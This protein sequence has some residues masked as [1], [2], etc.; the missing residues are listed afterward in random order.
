MNGLAT[1]TFV[2]E[3][4]D[5]AFYLWADHGMRG[6]TVVHV[7]AHVDYFPGTC[8]DIGSYIYHA[9]RRGLI[10]RFYWV[11]PD[12]TWQSPRLRRRLIG[13][14]IELGLQADSGAAAGISGSLQG[15]HFWVGPLG[16]LPQIDAPVLLD[17][18]VD[19][20]LTPFCYVGVR[21]WL[22]PWRL[23][24][25]LVR[26]LQ[27]RQIRWD[28]ATIA[29]SVEGGYTPMQWRLLAPYTQA[30]LEGRSPGF[31]LS[32]L[33]GGA[34]AYVLGDAGGARTHFA[35]AARAGAGTEEQAAAE[36]WLARLSLEAGDPD[37]ARRHVRA[38][39]SFGEAYASSWICPGFG[40]WYQGSTRAA[41]R[42]FRQ[43]SQALPEEPS[44]F[45]LWA[46]AVLQDDP[47]TAADLAAWAYALGPECAD[48]NLAL[49]RALL[50]KGEPKA[51]VAHLER[52]LA[53][54]RRGGRT[55]L[56]PIRSKAA[57]QAASTLA[58]VTIMKDLMK[59][60]YQVGN[61]ARAARFHD[62]L[63]QHRLMSPAD[64]YELLRTLRRSGPAVPALTRP[65]RGLPTRWQALVHRALRLAYLAAGRTDHLIVEWQVRRLYGIL[66]AP[67]KTGLGPI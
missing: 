29:A 5:E 8:A 1:R 53:L 57:P 7:D 15:L 40:F 51:A 23:P 36:V 61:A 66:S 67:G 19:Y 59:A 32:R 17:L 30:L 24:E 10:S 20:F 48:S 2:I 16:E 22:V 34:L 18:D 46:L 41:V 63:R 43:W 27:D 13:S 14:M 26:R 11:V 49:G 65:L 38:A 47:E 9:H 6:R 12:P 50:R 52:A 39:A 31:S 35:T 56:A 21:E 25:S 58:I 54:V 64:E 3:N 62:F 33:T 28:I 4:H 44:L 55:L 37:S 42:S 45:S 60:Y